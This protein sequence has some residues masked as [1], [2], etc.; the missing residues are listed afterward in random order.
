MG[1]RHVTHRAEA[2]LSRTGASFSGSGGRG[3][4]TLAPAFPIEA[5][6]PG[7]FTAVT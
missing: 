1:P 7:L 4:S 2:V 5:M 3:L 6:K